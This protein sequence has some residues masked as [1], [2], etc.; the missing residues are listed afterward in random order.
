ME[1]LEDVVVPAV[2]VEE[3]DALAPT[4]APE[5]SLSDVDAELDAAD[6]AA[7][8]ATEA[9]EAVLPVEP[10]A[11]EPDLEKIVSVISLQ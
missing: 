6:D 7:A 3:E 5:P 4:A 11:V 9:E 2:E 1:V 8:G 10:E